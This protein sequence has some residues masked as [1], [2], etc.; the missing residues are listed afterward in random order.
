MKSFNLTGR[1]SVSAGNGF[2]NL[3]IKKVNMSEAGEYICHEGLRTGDRTSTWLNVLG[4]VS[5]MLRT[6][7]L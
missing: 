6:Y 5:K 2:Y 3:T 4:E 7:S 1:Y